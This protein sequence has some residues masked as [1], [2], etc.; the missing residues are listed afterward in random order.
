MGK[1]YG[2]P[3]RYDPDFNGPVHNRSCTDILWLIVFILFLG[4]W[5]YVGY[6]TW[7]SFWHRSIQEVAAVASTQVWRTRNI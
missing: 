1:D 6:Y 7:R 2:E 4:A 3:I 5:G